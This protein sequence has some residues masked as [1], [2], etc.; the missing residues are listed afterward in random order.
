MKFKNNERKKERK[1]ERKNDLMINTKGLVRSKKAESR[2][3]RGRRKK[4]AGR[5]RAVPLPVQNVAGNVS[6]VSFQIPK[7]DPA[8]EMRVLHAI[9]SREALKEAILQHLAQH[10]ESV[11]SV[12]DEGDI[13]M[14]PYSEDL[15]RRLQFA[16]VCVVEAIQSWRTVLTVHI[17]LFEKQNYILTMAGDLDFM[18]FSSPAVKRLG[19]R[20][21][22]R[23]PLCIPAFSLERIAK[24]AFS[25]KIAEMLQ[26]GTLDPLRLWKAAEAVLEEE[27]IHGRL[28]NPLSTPAWA[29]KTMED[30]EQERALKRKQKL[31]ARMKAQDDAAAERA[32]ASNQKENKHQVR[33]EKKMVRREEEEEQRKVP[34]SMPDLPLRRRRALKD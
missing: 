24:T 29:A 33:G 21:N 22:R 20:A 14:D 7:I 16:G 12:D 28:E 30:R 19:N 32:K 10:R 15:L 6:M 31:A 34:K 9:S 8:K 25:D 1:K 13:L 4:D 17:R 5:R 2:G 11:A 18:H 3:G 27:S 26:C 23:N